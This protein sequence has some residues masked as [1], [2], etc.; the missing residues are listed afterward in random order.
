MYRG[1]LN[2]QLMWYFT[3]NVFCKCCRPRWFQ[4]KD[5]ETSTSSLLQLL[6]VLCVCVSV[7]LCVYIVLSVIVCSGPGCVCLCWFNL[8]RGVYRRGH[9][10]CD[11]YFFSSQPDQW[12][13]LAVPPAIY[14][15]SAQLHFSQLQLRNCLFT[16]V[17]PFLILYT[18][19]TDFINLSTGTKNRETLW[20]L[21]QGSCFS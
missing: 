15:A 5:K 13:W 8:C 12:S 10:V 11:L 3:G 16:A 9:T 7:Y 18:P 6:C 19:S 20:F 1:M 2:Q 14:K 17:S 4:I 21:V